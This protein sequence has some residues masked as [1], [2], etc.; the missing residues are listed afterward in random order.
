M[1][2]QFILGRAGTGK[3]N[4][5]YEEIKQNIDKKNK[6]YIITPEQFSYMAE[7]KLLEKIGRQAVINAEVLTFNRMADRIEAEF[8]GKTE[9][10]LP[11]TAGPAVPGEGTPEQDRL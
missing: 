11:G 9:K 7:K 4:H 8:G 6:T 1:S 2:I 5:C 10:H 3:S